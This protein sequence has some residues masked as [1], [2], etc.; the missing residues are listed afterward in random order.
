MAKQ[1]VSVK[2]YIE[3]LSNL[4]HSDSNPR[5]IK[6]P[7]HEQLKKSL[8]E[9]PEMKLL[10]EIVVDEDLV[11]LAGDKRTYALEELGYEDVT[12]KQVFG[13]TDKQKREFII[14]DNDHN[15]D[16]DPDIIANEWDVDELADWGVPKFK[17]PGADADKEDVNFEAEKTHDVTCPNCSFVFDPNEKD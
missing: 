2:V 4:K 3:K 7:R 1:D 13:L 8:Q 10:R 5:L 12:V 9:F 15:G 11:I 16:W 17:L 14:K 6:R